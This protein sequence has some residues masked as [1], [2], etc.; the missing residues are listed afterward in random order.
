MPTAWQFC[1]CAVE[2]DDGGLGGL[3]H[4]GQNEESGGARLCLPLWRLRVVDKE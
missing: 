2:W 1:G 4:V 3:M